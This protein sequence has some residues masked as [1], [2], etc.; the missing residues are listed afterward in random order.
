[1][2]HQMG[3]RFQRKAAVDQRL[4]R[5]CVSG[6]PAQSEGRFDYLPCSVN[7]LRW[8]ICELPT[9]AVPRESRLSMLEGRI[10]MQRAKSLLNALLEFEVAGA[11]A[12]TG[13]DQVMA[14]LA[15]CND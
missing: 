12:G 3:N 9:S 13:A 5:A 10:G 8:A 2:G 6:R 7:V 1:M 14:V 4:H 11:G 15:F